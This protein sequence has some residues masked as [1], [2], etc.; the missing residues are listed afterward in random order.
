MLPNAKLKDAGISLIVFKL[1]A[2]IYLSS[3]VKAFKSLT[4]E[5]LWMKGCKVCKLVQFGCMQLVGLV[6]Y[7]LAL[8]TLIEDSKEGCTMPIY[9]VKL[10]SK[11]DIADGTMAFYFEKPQGFTHKAGQYA[12]LTLMNPEETDSEGNIRTFTLA[13]APY[14]ESLMFATRMRDTAFKRVLKNMPIGTEITLDAPHGSFTLH[15]NDSVPAVFLTGGI[16]DRK[17]VV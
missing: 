12:D 3:R 17:S 2:A 13:N 5:S 8:Q 4:I 9:T 11:E 14:E 7:L 15:N 1:V 6:K 10:Q 16:G